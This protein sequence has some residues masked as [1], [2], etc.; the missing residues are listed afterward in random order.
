MKCQ[1]LFS[2]KNKKK[3][4]KISS[5]EIFTLHVNCETILYEKDVNLFYIN[6]TKCLLSKLA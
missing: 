2:L 1:I 6:N 3:Y 5:A 4:F